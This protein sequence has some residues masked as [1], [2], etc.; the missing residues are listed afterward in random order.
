MLFAF[1]QFEIVYN[2]FIKFVQYYQNSQC[3]ISKR[4]INYCGVQ[5][6]ASNLVSQQLQ[7]VGILIVL[8]ACT[9]HYVQCLVAHY[10]GFCSILQFRS[11]I[12]SSPNSFKVSVIIHTI[13]RNQY[14][15]PEQNEQ[16]QQQINSANHILLKTKQDL[17]PYAFLKLQIIKIT[18]SNLTCNDYFECFQNAE[19]YLQNELQK[20]Q[21]KARIDRISIMNNNIFIYAFIQEKVQ[22]LQTTLEGFTIDSTDQFGNKEKKEIFLPVCQG[23]EEIED[24]FTFEDDLIE[25]NEIRHR[26]KITIEK[27]FTK[28]YNLDSIEQEVYQ[29]LHQCCLFEYLQE[30]DPKYLMKLSYCLPTML[31]IS[32]QQKHQIISQTVLKRLKLAEQKLNKLALFR[33]GGMIFEVPNDHPKPPFTQLIVVII[34]I[35]LYF[36]FI[37]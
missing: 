33:H 31:S 37:N 9:S 25:M 3:G 22:H 10:A 17:F 2:Q 28:N 36:I 12:Q 8:I 34:F 21:F 29:K 5:F 4:L 18:D 35:I 20:A 23:K 26:I 7:H 32:N 15:P 1:Y 19:V 6:V 11:Y 27:I 30:S 24:T 16:K 14:L 13:I